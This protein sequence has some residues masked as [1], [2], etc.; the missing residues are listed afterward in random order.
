VGG[1]HRARQTQGNSF[2]AYEARSIWRCHS[3]LRAQRGP[4]GGEVKERSHSAVAAAAASPSAEQREMEERLAELEELEAVEAAEEL[5]ND[6]VVRQMRAL[7]MFEEYSERARFYAQRGGVPE[8]E[9]D[10]GEYY[11]GDEGDDAAAWA[12]EGGGGDMDEAEDA[13]GEQQSEVKQASGG[14]R[15]PEERAG[16][17]VHAE[18]ESHDV[19]YLARA[20]I[21]YLHERFEAADGVLRGQR[22]GEVHAKEGAALE[23]LRSSNDNRVLDCCLFF[24]DAGRGRERPVWLLSNDRNLAVKALAHKVRVLGWDKVQS[25][26]RGDA[27]ATV[28]ALEKGQL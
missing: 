17:T 22:M 10:D 7:D 16:Q 1:A 27:V 26:S 14:A 11:Y 6:N 15:A 25:V 9:W 13:H 28:D 19:G 23:E 20:A 3:R 5:E 4:D 21:R 12:A 2:V 8:E 24:Q 18:A